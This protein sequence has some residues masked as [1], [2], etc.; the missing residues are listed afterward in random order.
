MR[1]LPRLTALSS[2]PRNFWYR[3]NRDFFTGM[4]LFL[5]LAAAFSARVDGSG[6]VQVTPTTVMAGSWTTW[7]ITYTVGRNGI[8]DGGGIQ[9]QLPA[10]LFAWPHGP[11]FKSPQAS[12]QMVLQIGLPFPMRGDRISVSIDLIDLNV[13]PKI[14]IS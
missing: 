11:H 1:K 10:N 4:I 8:Q 6:T 2:Q 5:A 7:K 13:K 12:R 9:V 3:R 14:S